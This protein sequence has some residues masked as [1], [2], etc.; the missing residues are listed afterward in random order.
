MNTKKNYPYHVIF[1]QNEDL[2][3]AWTACCAA[4]RS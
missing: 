3:G 1:K 4:R 2:D